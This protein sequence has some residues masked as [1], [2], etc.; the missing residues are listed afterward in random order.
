ML[1]RAYLGVVLL[2]ATPLFPQAIS[3]VSSAPFQR[4]SQ[5]ATPPPV[6]GEAYPTVVGAEESS[7]YVRAG[8]VFN[9]SYIDNLFP[10]VGTTVAD[11]TYTILPTLD[12]DQTTP[13]RHITILYSPG[14]TFYEPTSALNQV[15]ENANVRYRVRTSPHS[16]FSV[17]DQFRYSSTAFGSEIFGAGGVSGGTPVVAPGIV[18]P[19]AKQL[20]NGADGEFTLQT[21]LNSMIGFSGMASTL[22]YPT[23][24]EATGLFDS[25]S[26]GGS[27]FY[28][29]R[30]SSGQYLGATYNYTQIFSNPSRAQIE[31]VIQSVSAFYAIYPKRTFTLSV[32]GGPQYLQLEQETFPAFSSWSPFLMASIGRQGLHTNVAASYAQSVTA[33]NGLL[34]PYHSKS[35]NL[36]TRWRMSRTWTTGASG[37]YAINNAVSSTL[38]IGSENGHTIS[39]SAMVA[40]SIGRQISFTLEYDRIHQSYAGIPAISNNPDV[41]RVTASISWEFM[42]PIGK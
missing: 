4:D 33:G 39:G 34:G 22:H 38:A 21:G 23:P 30:I 3:P 37:N 1:T 5:M 35:G 31:S 29:R 27:A 2:M 12:L 36:I 18:V 32:S 8:I 15:D 25:S 26:Q 19:F 16:T 7:N 20:T 14:F 40:R 41:D 6:S 10:G 13:R 28:N 11:T 17:G 42:R 24:S 9:T